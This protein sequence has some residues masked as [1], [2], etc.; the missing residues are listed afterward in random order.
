MDDKDEHDPLDDVGDPTQNAVTDVMAQL[1]GQP[2]T[3]VGQYIGG[4]EGFFERLREAEIKAQVDNLA[5]HIQNVV[6]ATGKKP[7]LTQAQVIKFQAWA[8]VAA[9]IPTTDAA[10]SAII[11]AALHDL[12]ENAETSTYGEAAE[13]LTNQGASLL[14]TAPAD[15][16]I[17]PEQKEERC[18]N[19]LTMLGL[20]SRPSATNLFS[21]FGVLIL[22]TALGGTILSELILP[23]GSILFPR[24]I[25]ASVGHD[26]IIDA[27]IIC[28]VIVA[29]EISL[30][31]RKYRLTDFGKSVREAAAPFYQRP[32]KLR[33]AGLLASISKRP[34]W[35]AFTLTVI[36]V[37]SPI[38]LQAL[39]RQLRYNQD[40]PIVILS[41]PPE[42]PTLARSRITRR[43]P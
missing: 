17:E 19:E 22:G 24:Y 21:Q 40:P 1:L 39:P 2:T 33:K 28:C 8:K 26:L 3:A 10:R 9:N 43:P 7:R 29:S 38:L 35:V 6:N 30:L 37:V 12:F 31:A 11:E 27:G 14:L 34:L 32:Q 36:S 42:A 13:R 23:Y 16:T 5:A 25:P 41:P 15:S 20:V 18:L 4:P